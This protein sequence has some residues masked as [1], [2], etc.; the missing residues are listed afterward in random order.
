MVISSSCVSRPCEDDLL[1]NVAGRFP[2]IPQ[3]GKQETETQ[4]STDIL[5]PDYN[6]C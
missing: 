1:P 5:V 4:R 3:D 2:A 6:S